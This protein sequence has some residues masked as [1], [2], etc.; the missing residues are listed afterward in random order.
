MNS[1][2]NKSSNIGDFAN[3]TERDYNN[4]LTVEVPISEVENSELDDFLNNLNDWY[5]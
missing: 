2:R 4:H 1:Y 5:Q 3:T